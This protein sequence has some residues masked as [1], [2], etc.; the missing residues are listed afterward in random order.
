M[1]LR[2]KKECNSMLHKLIDHSPDLKR[3]RDEGFELAIKLPFL[4]VSGVPYFNSKK[5]ICYGTLVTDLTLAGNKTGK[6]KN[7]VIHFIGEHPCNKDGTTMASLIYNNAGSNLLHDIVVNRSFSHKPAGGYMNYYD[8]I[9]TYIAVISAPVRS[10][11]Y[12]IT[13]QTY[14]LIKQEDGDSEFNY[15]DTNSSRSSIAF[16]TEKLKKHRIAIIGL[17]GTGSYV[18]DFIAKT[19]VASINLFDGDKF[20]THNA[21]R[22]PGA[23]DSDTLVEMPSKVDYFQNIY[24]RMHKN[25]LA[26]NSFIN[27]A[28]LELLKD[29]D[30]VFMCLDKG[31]VKKD[32]INFLGEHKVSFIDTGMGIETTDQHSLFGILRLTTGLH[33]NS[34]HITSKNLISFAE[35]DENDAYS[36]N[37]QIAELNALSATLAVIKWKK[38]CGFYHETDYENHSLYI[39]DDN[40]ILNENFKA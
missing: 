30:F 31:D 34:D 23:P 9:T 21:F 12:N 22:A 14:K 3:L 27:S 39:M 33:G 11:D 36:Q 7:H 35:D 4:L 32:I 15:P 19:P 37:I 5:E 6:P 18:L 20:Q 40:K 16:I 26:H 38:I 28:N 24:S 25:I 8:K 10:Y 1:K 29:M 17:G 2:L 13:P